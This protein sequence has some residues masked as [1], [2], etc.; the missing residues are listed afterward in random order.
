MRQ[1]YLNYINKLTGI[2]DRDTVTARD[3]RDHDKDMDA[4]KTSLQANATPANKRVY[5][6]TTPPSETDRRIWKN[7]SSSGIWASLAGHLFVRPQ[8]NYLY[9]ITNGKW[10]NNDAEE[11]PNPGIALGAS[12]PLVYSLTSDIQEVTDS[13]PVTFSCVASDPD[14]VVVKYEWD[15]GDGA[16]VQTVENTSTHSYGLDGTYTPKVRAQDN[17]GLWSSWVTHNTGGVTVI[18]VE[19]GGYFGDRGLFPASY[20]GI[21][22]IEYVN[23]LVNGNAAI[24]GNQTQSHCGVCFSDSIKCVCY[25]GA[26]NESSSDHTV[27]TAIDYS[28]FSTIGNAVSWGSIA[29]Q[30]L[31]GIMGAYNKQRGIA[32]GGWASSS[33]SSTIVSLSFVVGSSYSSFG[34]LVYACHVGASSNNSDYCIF[35]G[36]GTS[37][38]NY[39]D[40]IQRLTIMT[41][42]NST[43]FGL[44]SSNRSFFKG[45]FGGD[46]SLFFAGQT[47]GGTNIRVIEYVNITTP[48]NA[49]FFGNVSANCYNPKC[50]SNNVKGLAAGGLNRGSTIE[51]INIDT[52]GS[53]TAFGNLTASRWDGYGASG[54]PT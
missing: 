50:L 1:G 2:Q 42:S 22:Q 33:S 53:I 38:S 23:I 46:R 48:G 27:T 8:D 30:G 37:A 12:A 52:V 14:G 10:Y 6:G 4:H 31:L 44:L 16:V 20:N 5:A 32:C 40:P 17:S 36:G 35:A 41:E 54:S 34:S 29:H 19:L 26:T 11:I 3:L 24:F 21:S 13:D 49:I 45:T 51:A 39:S 18:E 43:H 9:D 25:G 7:S 15:F 28:N 47:L